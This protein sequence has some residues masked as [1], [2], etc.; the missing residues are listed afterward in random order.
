[1]PVMVRLGELRLCLRLCACA[2]TCP[3][4]VPRD[5]TGLTS[6]DFMAEPEAPRVGP[7]GMRA[8]MRP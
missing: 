5:F 4:L 1:M 8:G 6:P 3:V 2:C 7:P